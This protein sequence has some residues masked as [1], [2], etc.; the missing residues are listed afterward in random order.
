MFTCF[1][2]DDISALKQQLGQLQENEQRL[3][4]EK[5]VAES[6]FGMKRAKFK[7]LYIQKEG[8]QKHVF[9]HMF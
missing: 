6:E 2:V 5:E 3:L 1:I 9:Y 8:M 4:K 7:E